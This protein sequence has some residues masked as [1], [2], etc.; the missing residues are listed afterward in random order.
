MKQVSVLLLFT[1]AIAARGKIF[2]EQKLEPERVARTLAQVEETWRHEAGSF[3]ACNMTASSESESQHSCQDDL[4]SFQ[5]SCSKVVNSI[6]TASDGD[7]AKVHEYLGV[8]CGQKALSDW[9]VGE[10]QDLQD[11]L[12][13]EMSVDS[14]TNRQSFDPA[15]ACKAFWTKFVRTEQQQAEVQRF[16]E[17]T[18][19]KTEEAQR[20]KEDE[21]GD[22]KKAQEAES[23]EDKVQERQASATQ[24]AALAASKAAE[25][26]EMESAKAKASAQK[27]AEN[28]RRKMKEAEAAEEQSQKLQAEATKALTEAK[29]KTAAP[30][31]KATTKA[32]K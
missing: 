29:E 23:E 22:A 13:N 27:D 26:V 7:R 8:V 14:F 31:A 17:E 20:K 12:E 24:K 15:A 3:V 9:K 18:R 1:P 19:K 32:A 6:V 11:T 28:A 21:A 16:E 2:L 30:A 4:D 25:E 10:C 5:E